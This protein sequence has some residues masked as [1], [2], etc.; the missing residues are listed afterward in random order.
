MLVQLDNLCIITS[1]IVTNASHPYRE[2]RE[3]KRNREIEK[4]ID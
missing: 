1:R 2:R 4:G 3:R